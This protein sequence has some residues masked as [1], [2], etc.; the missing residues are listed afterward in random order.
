MSLP[1]LA[2]RYMSRFRCITDKCEA[3]CCAGLLVPVSE[4][5]WARVQRLVA[6]DT[7]VE[8]QPVRQRDATTGAESLFLPERGD[9]HCTFL[10][11][12]KLCALHRRHGDGVLPDICVTF[13]RVTVRWDEQLEMAGTL[14]C[15]E[16]AR[17]ALL[18]EDALESEPIAPERVYRPEAAKPSSTAGAEEGWGF[19]SRAVRATALRLLRRSEVPLTVRL[20]ALGELGYQL[21]PFYFQKT[22]AFRGEGRAEAEARLARV[23]EASASPEALEAARKELTPA[24]LPGAFLARLYGSTLKGRLPHPIARCQRL[25]SAVLESY[26]GPDAEP[27][28][29]W[30]L[31]EERRERLELA[32]GARVRQYFSHHALNHWMTGP[33]LS[34]PSVLVDVFHL[35]LSGALLRWALLGHPEVVR[36][37]EADAAPEEARERLDAAAV[38]TFQV[39]TRHVLRA[40]DFMA[41]AVAF[42]GDGGE[43][44]RELL[45]ALLLGYRDDA[46][47]AA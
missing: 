11:P 14:A 18:A 12:D 1:P 38:E 32:H 45:R 31:Y 16:V 47:P 6:R 8:P 30:R 42:A 2:P 20:Q 13:P 3:T 19:H 17:L 10:E 39:L 41:Y 24:P 25:L 4:A 37:C 21:H 33:F 40:P 28:A 36:L 23:L 35:V 44:S 7:G 27:E 26:G 29:L 34:A 22:E 15:P 43:Q 5:E 9:G 46:L